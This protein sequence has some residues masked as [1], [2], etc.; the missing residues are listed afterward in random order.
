MSTTFFLDSIGR[1]TAEYENPAEYEIGAKD[2]IG[3]FAQ[4]RQVNEMGSNPS[5][6]VM[7]FVQTVEVQSLIIPYEAS[8]HDLPM[9]FV[10]FDESGSTN[11]STRLIKSN[12]RI[13]PNTKFLMEFDKIQ[14]DDAGNEK[15]IHYKGL[16]DQVIRFNGNHRLSV[17]ITTRS[18]NVLPVTVVDPK[19]PDVQTLIT[20]TTV[21]YIRDG[22]YDNHRQQLLTDRV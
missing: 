3:W 17:K 10:D 13:D 11:R 21:P 14:F 15:W 8:F 18:G 9:L 19:D 16:N 5:G 22:S 2:V 6:R 20:F 12:T 7:N 1:D 4:H